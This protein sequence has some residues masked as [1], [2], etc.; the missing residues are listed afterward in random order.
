MLLCPAAAQAAVGDFIGKPVASVRLVLD[1]RDT[2]DP[3]LLQVV[4]TRVGRPLS[5]LEVRE[6]VTHLFSLGR[7]DDVSV[8]ATMAANGVALRYDLSPVHVVSK[9][10]F[11]GGVNAPGIDVGELRRVVVARYGTS[12]PLG[13]ADDLAAAIVETLRERGY[14]HAAVVPRADIEHRSES[15]VLVFTVEPGART[16]I[17]RV[18]VEGTPTVPTS[19]LLARLDVAPGAPYEPDALAARIAR[20]ID[21]RRSR[22][23][24]E[25][26]IT[27][28]VVFSPDDRVADLTLS[29]QPGPHVRVVFTGDS[30]PADKREE[31]VPVEREGSADEDLLEDSSHRIEEYLRG[32]GYRDAAAPHTRQEAN[33]ELLITFA[34]HRGPQYRVARVELSGVTLLSAA[35]LRAGLRTREGEPF[36]DANLDLDQ[37][38]IEAFYRARG[39]ASVKVQAEARPEPR[40]AETSQAAIVATIAVSEGV[41]TIVGA[42]SIAG[43]TS[44]PD[45]ELR[46][47]LSLQPGTPYFDARIRSDRDALELAYANRGFR[48]VSVDAQPGFSADGAEA[49]PVFTVREGPR[50]LVGHVLIAGNVRTSAQTIERELQLKPGDPLSLSAEYESQR[51]LAALQLFRRAPQITELR[52]GDENERDLL[53]TVEEAAPTTLGYGG[54]LEGRL[55]VVSS[56]GDN[57]VATQK[58]ELAPRAFVDLGRRNLFG[59][60]RSINLFGSASLHPAGV[61]SDARVGSG[62][63]EYALRG[64]F[65]EPRLLGTEV[66]GVLTATLE[67]QIRSSFN[68]ARRSVT[69][70]ASRRLTRRVS[71][72]GAYQLQRTQLLDVRVTPDQQPV[73]DRVFTQVRLSSFSAQGFYDTRDDPVDSTN[74]NYL[75]AFGQL[76]ARAIGSEVGFAKSVFTAQSFRMLPRGHGIVFAAQARLG[77]ATGFPR[78]VVQIDGNGAQVLVKDVS[79]LPE[80]ERFFAG[81]DTTVRGFALETLGRPDTIKDGFPIG[82]NAETIFNA[83]LR[84][85][86]RGGLGMVGF[87]DSGNVFANASDIDLL[88]LRSAVGIGLRY[89]SPVGPIRVDLGFKVKP[90][91][92]EGLTAWFISF[93]QAF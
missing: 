8:D 59:K 72:S 40:A 57:S 73:I 29:V 86:V 21:S 88:E 64:T 44:V 32:Q 63:T 28:A 2:Q 92:G 6:T 62:F 23:Y 3:G 39:F 30:L 15:A 37:A 36:S 87:V 45:A 48:L 34:L 7:F 56:E 42:V 83:E 49:D 50:V 67:Q 43:N 10:T 22:G 27:P 47:V 71:I 20:Y 85:P 46:A 35:E 89:K 91:P 81:G 84:V 31:L 61:S 13:R 25:A 38:A 4:E 53:V 1:G 55:R 16:T 33:G 14:R 17:G 75:S 24:Y 76:A 52:H 80:P 19:E 60:N 41:R 69:A 26:R 79:D 51:R 18:T 68:F 9:I 90:Q 78:D 12:P 70:Q 66:D 54:G 74:G 11:A 77:V 93:G 5:M 65:H 82:G 58:F